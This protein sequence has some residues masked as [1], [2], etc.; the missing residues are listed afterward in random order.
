MGVMAEKVG[1]QRA[2]ASD[3]ALCGPYTLPGW[4]P[5][6]CAWTAPLLLFCHCPSSANHSPL[7]LSCLI[8]HHW[9]ASSPGRQ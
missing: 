7:R 9:R 6:A 2:V 1:G 5:P 4:L 3:P 8:P